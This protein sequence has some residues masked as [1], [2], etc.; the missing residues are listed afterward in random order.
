[1]TERWRKRLGDLDKASPSDE[2]FRRAAAGPQIPDESIPLPSRGSRVV[3]GV[4]AFVV[5]ALAVSVFV[6]PALRMD[7]TAGAGQAVLP[8]W[9]AHTLDE[10]ERIQQ[11]A[12][13]GGEWSALLDAGGT[14]SRFATD[15]LGWDLNAFSVYGTLADPDLVASGS[16]NTPTY[17][18]TYAPS[19]GPST[20]APG[21]YTTYRLVG[22][23]SGCP[24]ISGCEVNVTVFQPLDQ[25]DDGVWMVLEVQSQMTT[26]SVGTGD[27]LIE[28][29]VVAGGFQIGDGT[30]V[31]FGYQAGA[32]GCPAQSVSTDEYRSPDPGGNML[33]V[34]GG[35]QLTVNLDELRAS[36][37]C[38]SPQAGHVFAA[39]AAQPI[40]GD[41][42]E[43]PHPPLTGLSA[44]PVAFEWSEAPP[45]SVGPTPTASETLAWTTHTDP[46][47]WTIDV[48]EGWTTLRIDGSDPQG[49]YQGEAFS[50]GAILHTP[51][52][53]TSLN[54]DQPNVLLEIYHAEGDSVTPPA[55]DSAFPLS[56]DDLQAQEGGL[57]GTFRGDGLEFTL[58]IRLSGGTPTA[59]QDDIL[60]RMVGSIS[61]QPWSE[62]EV[63]NGYVALIEQGSM[64]DNVPKM[65]TPIDGGSWAVSV[66]DGAIW[67]VRLPITPC[68]DR[69]HGS[70][71]LT[72][73]MG[74][75]R[76]RCG[77]GLEASYNGDGTPVV[78]N[79]ET[80]NDDLPGQTAVISWDG[81]VLAPLEP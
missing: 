43:D 42:L 14:V 36:S 28:G 40:V 35:A 50:D 38:T 73:Q 78:G 17:A 52:G 18:P 5:F 31:R 61:F 9:P 12:R 47:G 10:A 8:L 20:A 26:I 34:S 55:D 67:T 66:K 22:A 37:D 63:R 46:L 54:V 72:M 62:G 45:S 32:D 13:D 1:M 33:L 4:A 30:E 48:P 25:G 59:A 57:T 7:Q 75:I 69:G 80:W 44:V 53:P 6:V 23:V 74:M 79:P 65:V 71:D 2:V 11:E 49:A 58:V 41:P 24:Y 21:P 15:V 19:G 68:E 39:S 16:T 3:G 29:D 56:Y 64:A 76:V 27:T 70:T 60:H 51:A 81:W 77:D